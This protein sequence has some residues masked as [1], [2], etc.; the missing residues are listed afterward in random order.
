MN[1][2][3]N[4]KQFEVSFVWISARAFEPRPYSAPPG[5]A[6]DETLS[7][8]VQRMHALLEEG[9]RA[10]PPMTNAQMERSLQEI[11]GLVSSVGQAIGE[12]ELQPPT[13]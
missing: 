6:P 9:A 12:D 3:Q 5:N 7:G 10:P 1:V 4:H 13:G 11:H 2:F 8:H